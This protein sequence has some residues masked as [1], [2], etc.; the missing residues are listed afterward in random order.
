MSRYLPLFPILL[1]LFV[2]L[3][4]L[5]IRLARPRFAYFWL[6]AALGALLAWPMV[7]FTRTYIPHSLLLVTEPLGRTP[8]PAEFFPM[9]PALLVD[10]ISWSYA[11]ALVTLALAVILTDVARAADADWMAWAGSLAITA[12]GLFAVLSGN[13]LTLLLGWTAIDLAELAILLIEVPQSS[14]REQIIL[15]FSARLAGSVL[16]VIGVVIG[17]GLAAISTPSPSLTFTTISPQIR[18]YL[19]LAAGLRLGVLPMHTPFLGGR[20]LRRGLGTV[21]CMV[22][23]ASSLILLARIASAGAP[24]RWGP[25]L[26]GL[27]GLAALYA[28][29]YWASAR[30]ELDGRRFWIL[31]MAALSLAAAA[32]AQM[33]ASLALGIALLLSGGLLFLFSARHRWLLPI[34]GLGLLGFSGLPYTPAWQAMRLYAPPFGVW[35]FLFLIAQALF[36]VGYARHVLR[37]EPQL[38]GVERWVWV[39][40]P[41]GLILLPLTGFLIAWWGRLSGAQFPTLASSWPSLVAMGIALILVVLAQRIPRLPVRLVSS[42]H[43]VFSFSWL[44]QLFWGV[45]R[46]VGRFLALINLI[47]EGEGGILW[48]ILLLTLLLS[49]LGQ[50]SQ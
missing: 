37:P 7:L 19:L 50:F 14:T 45:Y 5:A 1:L 18:V 47:L 36:L 13:L 12:L 23:A 42:L 49:L 38:T 48:T 29:V 28:G 27:A 30:D 25:L 24:A 44:Y 39:I 9:S 41:W 40:Y 4:M 21:L 26:L 20:E 11:M 3:L 32:R 8:L 16:A 46:L 33:E 17:A 6:V 10:P 35:E 2:P 22:P 31:G 34:A 15:A 43:S